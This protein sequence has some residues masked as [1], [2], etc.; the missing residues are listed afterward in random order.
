MSIKRFEIS[1]EEYKKSHLTRAEYLIIRYKDYIRN[2][3]FMSGLTPDVIELAFGKSD[4]KYQGEYNCDCWGLQLDGVR[5]M[6]ISADGRGTTVESETG[7]VDIIKKFYKEI[8]DIFLKIDN[9]KIETL[10][11]FLK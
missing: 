2:L 10:K 11:I 1:K 9:P 8:L 7:N 5:F 4:F 3:S 6:I